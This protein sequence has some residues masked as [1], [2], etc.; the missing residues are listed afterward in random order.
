MNEAI[1][2]DSAFGYGHAIGA[3]IEERGLPYKDLSVAWNCW[4]LG[5]PYSVHVAI[6]TDII[7]QHPACDGAHL[8][9]ATYTDFLKFTD[10]VCKLDKG[11]VLNIGSA[12]L[13]PEVFLKALSI[14]RNLGHL[15]Y[16]ITAANFDMLPHYRPRVNVVERPTAEGGKGYNFQERHERTIPSLWMALTGVV[17]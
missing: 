12:V 14:S 8:G 4:K 10:A 17:H 13:M 2:R 15:T 16:D 6:G 7:H 5:I 9:A 11:V 1:N 3:M